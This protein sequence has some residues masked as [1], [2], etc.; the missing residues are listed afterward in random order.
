MIIVLKQ[1]KKDYVLE[2]QTPDEPPAL[3][4]VAHDAWL[5]DVDDSLDVS[6][7][8]LASMVL[9]LQRD[10][11][12]YT[13]FE[14]IKHLNEM[15]G[16]QDRIERFDIMTALHTM[17]MEENGNSYNSFIM[18]YNM[19]G[20]EKP[21]SM[22]HGMLKTAEKNILSKTPQVLM[23]REGKVK[24][25]KGKNFKGKPQDG[26]GKRKKSPQN[27][28][29]RK[30]E[31]VAK[32]DTCFECGE[33]NC[34]K[35]LA[36]LKNKK[37]GEGPSGISIF[38]IEMRLF[39]FSS[40]TWVLDTSCG[41]HICNSLQGFRK[42]KELKANEMVLHVGNRARVALQAIG[43]FAL[44]LASV[45]NQLDKTIKILRSDIGGEY[46]SQEFQDHLRSRGIISQLT[47]PRTPHLNG[48]SKRIDRTLLDM[49]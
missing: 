15:F 29:P 43:K 14:M 39:T 12:H 1:E 5:K 32:D 40:N 36:E 35:Y 19:N 47:P 18:N 45:E 17:K 20:W 24:K 41:T 10:L 4:E 9:D 22:L 2:N 42:S 16:K 13:A 26:K 3:P 6:Y 46:L 30:K 25:N 11:E 38:M 8:M 21:I 49:V 37:V 23:I 48:V 27:P 34:P 44:C 7:L 31:K 28:S 33:R